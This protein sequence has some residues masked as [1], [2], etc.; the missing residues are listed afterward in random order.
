MWH[1]GLA[2]TWSLALF[3]RHLGPSCAPGLP[4]GPALL[5]W[6]NGFGKRRLVSQLEK[7][8]GRFNKYV[9]SHM[10]K[11]S[12]KQ[13]KD[14]RGRLGPH[15]TECTV[16]P[17]RGSLQAEQQEQ[18]CCSWY[19]YYPKQGKQN[20]LIGFQFQNIAQTPDGG[21]VS[22]LPKGPKP[23]CQAGGC[24]AGW[25]AQPAGP[26]LLPHRGWHSPRLAG[27]RS[28]ARLSSSGG[29]VEGF[30]GIFTFRW[31]GCFL[32]RAFIQ[33]FDEPF[34]FA[35]CSQALQVMPCQRWRDFCKAQGFRPCLCVWELWVKV[36]FW[37]GGVLRKQ[38][39]FLGLW[40]GWAG[41]G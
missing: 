35:C 25:A 8:A 3:P 28:A 14:P 21:S 30:S 33:Q 32:Q 36:C 24:A 4:P 9:A 29:F 1:R 27:S 17:G 5:F 13:L 12:G 20:A 6:R 37:E 15:P 10:N 31:L 26:C 7:S 2:A 22:V 34:S 16:G 18:W 41:A 11:F 39:A 23:D 38:S 19:S 40:V